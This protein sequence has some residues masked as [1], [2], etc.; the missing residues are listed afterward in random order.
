MIWNNMKKGILTFL[1]VMVGII[2]SY[3]QV[4]FDGRPGEK[5]LFGDAR[6]CGGFVSFAGK[7]AYVNNTSAY[8]S[9]GKAAVV[10]GSKVNLGIAGYG[11]LTDV[12]SDQFA[13]D[14]NEYFIEMTYGGIF[15]EPVFGSDQIIHFTMP[16]VF[17]GGVSALSMSRPWDVDYEFDDYTDRE[18]F[19]AAETGMNLELN[20]FRFLRLGVG[21]SY[22]FV[23]ETGIFQRTN[24]DLS[25]WSG[26]VALKLGWF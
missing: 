10:F 22:R 21:L 15:I 14:G 5:T 9:G 3:A 18:L 4:R 11:L 13:V 20:L 16:L 19:Y 25:G 17:G 7:L 2:M 23:G 6:P 8:F 24:T 1:A 12:G 26:N